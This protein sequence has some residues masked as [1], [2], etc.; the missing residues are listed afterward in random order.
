MT[1]DIELGVIGGTGFYKFFGEATDVEVTTPHGSPSTPISIATVAGR[2]VGFLAR[3]GRHHQFLPSAVPYKANLH[4]LKSLGARQ[5]IAFN[6]VGSLQVGIR[7]GD[8]VLC[9]QFIDRTSGRPDTIFSGA[10]GAHISSAE[11]YCGRLRKVASAALESVPGRFHPNG[12]VV[13]IQG[14]RF[15]SRAESKWFTDMGWHLVNMT[16]YPEV[17]IAR[18]LELCYVNLSYVTDYDVAAKEI[19]AAD[20]AEPV[21]HAMVIREFNLNSSRIEQIVRALIGAFKPTDDCT[22]RHAL[23]NARVAR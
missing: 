8:F 22:C 1:Q 4:A 21:S 15:S 9:D 2:R 3:H 23:D 12:T 19:A 6:T 5:I 7:R 13:V 20:D 17:A 18:E 14:P 10:E 16:Q 11:P